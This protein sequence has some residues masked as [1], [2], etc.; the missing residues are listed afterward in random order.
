MSSPLVLGA[1]Q[2]VVLLH[3][4]IVLVGFKASEPDE[5]LS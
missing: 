3:F 1:L 5:P 4:L 2:F